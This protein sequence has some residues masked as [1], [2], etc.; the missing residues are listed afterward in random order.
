[1]RLLIL[2]FPLLL[3]ADALLQKIEKRNSED[4]RKEI[5]R[6]ER[7]LQ[8]VKKSE[9]LLKESRNGNWRE[10]VKRKKLLKKY[11]ERE[12]QILKLKREIDEKRADIKSLL[13]GAKRGSE[14]VLQLINTSY[15]TADMDRKTAEK[16]DSLQ[17]SGQFRVEDLETLW[18]L[19]QS[20]IIRSGEIRDN[21][22]SYRYGT[23]SIVDKSGEHLQYFPE[24]RAS[25]PYGYNRG[26]I[27]SGGLRTAYIDISKGEF[28][29]VQSSIK[30]WS[31]RVNDGGVV[32]YIILSLGLLAILITIYRYIYLS[33]VWL[34]IKRQMSSLQT[35]EDSNPLGRLLQIYHNRPEQEYDELQTRL[36]GGVVDEVYRLKK[37]ESLIKLVSTVAPLLGLLG[38]VIGMIL[39]FQS[40][41]ANGTNDP[42]LMADGISQALVTTMLGLIVAIPTLFGYLFVK[43]KSDR[44]V[45][46]LDE[47]S[48]GFIAESIEN[49]RKGE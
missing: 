18:Y 21:G 34:S 28:F 6:K 5:E 39:T 37:G 44:I 7:F 36:Q 10:T 15:T 49:S 4:L 48:A 1:V 20:E 19:M 17:K 45:D 9:A 43:S 14:E 32:G 13:D 40:I 12:A 2:L 42:R 24:E 41:T 33:L 8:S 46:I 22:A 3:S 31:E 23:F 26:L 47:Q 16:V 11:D 30:S 27:E 35:P 29:K 25:I 38:T